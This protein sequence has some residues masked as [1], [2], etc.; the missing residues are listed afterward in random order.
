[1]RLKPHSNYWKRLREIAKSVATVEGRM[2]II[3][4]KYV[5]GKGVVRRVVN[6]P[7]TARGIYRRLK[8]GV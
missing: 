2:L 1:M 6:H 4:E 7:D 3:Q 5:P 8:R